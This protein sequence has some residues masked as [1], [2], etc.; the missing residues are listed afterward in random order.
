MSGTKKGGV[1]R[2]VELKPCPFCGGKAKLFPCTY[3]REGVFHSYVVRCTECKGSTKPVA[4]EDL[5]PDLSG[6]DANTAA[7]LWN[8]REGN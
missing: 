2:M 3:G 8:R 6:D 7:R 5:N 4:T 1:S